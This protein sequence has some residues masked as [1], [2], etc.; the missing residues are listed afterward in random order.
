MTEMHMS[1]MMMMEEQHFLVTSEI[2]TVRGQDTEVGGIDRPAVAPA[3]R[4]IIIGLTGSDQ[5]GDIAAGINVATE[6][7]IRVGQLKPRG[8]SIALISCC[9]S[10]NF[11]VPCIVLR[12]EQT[13]IGAFDQMA[14]N[15]EFVFLSGVGSHATRPSQKQ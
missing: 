4:K 15:F 9:A 12:G 13:L 3:T 6:V 5:Y 7:G 8:S 2:S 10:W 11:V 14:G 1:E